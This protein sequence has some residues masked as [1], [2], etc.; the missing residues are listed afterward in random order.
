MPNLAY[1][2]LSEKDI[3]KLALQGDEP[4]QPFFLLK[5]VLVKYRCYSNLF[6][7]G[8]SAHVHVS[9]VLM[10]SLHFGQN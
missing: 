5:Q 6:I 1:I 8:M 9:N 3:L 7:V 10:D 4:L 2:A